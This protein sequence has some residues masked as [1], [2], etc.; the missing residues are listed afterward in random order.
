MQNPNLPATAEQNRGNNLDPPQI[1]LHARPQAFNSQSSEA[2]RDTHERV[3]LPQLNGE[4]VYLGSVCM[5][6]GSE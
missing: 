2:K 4:A 1:G 5:N 3:F 6:D